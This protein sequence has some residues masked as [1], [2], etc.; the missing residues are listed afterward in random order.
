M[1]YS[2]EYHRF[3]KIKSYKTVNVSWS[4]MYCFHLKIKLNKIKLT[5]PELEQGVL[6]LYRKSVLNFFVFISKTSVCKVFTVFLSFSHSNNTFS[7]YRWIKIEI[8]YWIVFVVALLWKLM[9]EIRPH[10]ITGNRDYFIL[11]FRILSSLYK[12]LLQ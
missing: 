9:G 7:W 5:W 11:E 8:P 2:W 1:S 6:F 10:T 12:Q 3:P 4:D